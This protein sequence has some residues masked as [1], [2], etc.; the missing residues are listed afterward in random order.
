MQTVGRS[1]PNEVA[2]NMGKGYSTLVGHLFGLKNIANATPNRLKGVVVFLEAPQ[3]MPDMAVWNGPWLHSFYPELLAATMKL[4]DLS[5]F[6]SQSTGPDLKSKIIASACMI[7][8]T[9]YLKGRWKLIV[10]NLRYPSAY[11]ISKSP[12]EEIRWD[13]QGIPE[14]RN[15]AINISREQIKSQSAISNEFWEKSV[16][17]RLHDE[18]AAAGGHLVLF[19]M[20]LSS[21][22][23][24]VNLTDIG[25]KNKEM[26]YS[27]LKEADIPVL[28]VNFKTT[29]DDF[30][31]LWHLRATRNVEYTN[32]LAQAYLNYKDR[33]GW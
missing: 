25:I 31:D 33:K 12:S 18:I 10:N 28:Q 2:I 11:S 17:K 26:L 23:A 14:V 4:S 21:V 16:L 1:E 15:S 3:G 20:P 13:D 29:D 9:I 6:W 19:N 32:V 7:S 30:P 27:F 5:S 8:K 22:Q 24:K